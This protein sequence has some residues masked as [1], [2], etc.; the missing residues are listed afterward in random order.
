MYSRRFQKFFDSLEELKTL[1][2]AK[3]ICEDAGYIVKK[4]ND[5]KNSVANCNSHSLKY[6]EAGMHNAS[7]INNNE[8]HNK[9]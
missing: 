8:A 9:A 4:I 7:T 1:L 5:K 2:Q 6:H 3:K